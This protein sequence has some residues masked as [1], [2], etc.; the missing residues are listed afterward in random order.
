MAP[1]I[2][3]LIWIFELAFWVFS[4]KYLNIFYFEASEVQL[5]PAATRTWRPTGAGRYNM[6]SFRYLDI[7]LT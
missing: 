6:R 7:F 2:R 1:K 5:R 3:L 4:Y